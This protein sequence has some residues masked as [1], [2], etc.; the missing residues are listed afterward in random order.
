MRTQKKKKKMKCVS[1]YS[2]ICGVRLVWFWHF[3]SCTGTDFLLHWDFFMVFLSAIPNSNFSDFSYTFFR[4][5]EIL[6]CT[7]R[8]QT[9]FYITVICATYP[10]FGDHCERPSR[11]LC[12]RK[13]Y[14]RCYYNVLNSSKIS[15]FLSISIYLH[16]FLNMSHYD[17]WFLW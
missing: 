10:G 8:I 5:F 4:F 6:Y 17:N 1:F 15:L 13:E 2:R 3:S 11:N 7:D 14:Q 12:S 16:P 9:T